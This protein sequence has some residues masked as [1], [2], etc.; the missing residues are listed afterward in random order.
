MRWQGMTRTIAFLAHALPAARTALGLP[1]FSAS[2]AYEITFPGRT[3]LIDFHAACE[4]EPP[5]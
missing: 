1:E 4:N 2:W 3:R 5:G